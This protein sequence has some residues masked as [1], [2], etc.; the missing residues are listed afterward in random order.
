MLFLTFL[1]LIRLYV[2]LFIC[3]LIILVLHCICN[4]IPVQR[5]ELL[6]WKLRFIK[7]NIINLEL[8]TMKP[9]PLC[10]RQS[11]LPSGIL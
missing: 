5:F 11:E 3:N 10:Q 7:I 4:Y 2:V 6:F 9:Q 1:Y 8:G